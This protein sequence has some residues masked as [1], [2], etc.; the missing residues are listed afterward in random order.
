VV[1][2]AVIGILVALIALVVLYGRDWG[3]AKGSGGNA[4]RPQPAR[5]PSTQPKGRASRHLQ[6]KLLK[7]MHGDRKGADRLLQQAKL[8]YGGKSE[9]WY[10]EKVIFDLERDRWR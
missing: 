7:L 10:V 8:K 5:R 3:W 9:D 1:R 6:A 2:F 4:Q